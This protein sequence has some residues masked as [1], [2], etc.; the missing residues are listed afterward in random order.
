[1]IDHKVFLV[2]CLNDLQAAS[3]SVATNSGSAGHRVMAIELLSSP[4]D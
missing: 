3:Q 4:D 1:M 2:S